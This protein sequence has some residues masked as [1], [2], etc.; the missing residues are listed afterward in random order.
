[1]IAVSVDHDQHRGGQG[2]QLGAHHRPVLAD[3]QAE[4][5]GVRTAAAGRSRASGQTDREVHPD[6][7]GL[8]PGPGPGAV[9]QHDLRGRVSG[10]QHRHPDARARRTGARAARAGLGRERR[11]R[12]G[13]DPTRPCR[14]GPGPAITGPS[15]GPGPTGPVPTRPVLVGPVRLV[16]P[17]VV[18]GLVRTGA[19]QQRGGVGHR[20][21]GLPRGGRG[22]GQLP[23]QGRSAGERHLGPQLGQIQG[24]PV[25]TTLTGQPQHRQQW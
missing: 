4:Q 23:V 8:V 14:T 18:G 11:S 9:E 3:G 20:V 7:V 22:A 19:G 21:V 17:A 10:P 2:L 16:R 12:N 6:S 25:G 5:V 13:S 24:E 15:F 1:M